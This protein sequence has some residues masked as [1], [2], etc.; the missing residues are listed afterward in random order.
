MG[1]QLLAGR[2][3]GWSRGAWEARFEVARCSPNASPARSLDRG[4]LNAEVARQ[5]AIFE[6]QG[7]TLE[8][9]AEPSS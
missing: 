6:S 5:K 4:D 1:S 2:K 3:A 7:G 8:A 9:K